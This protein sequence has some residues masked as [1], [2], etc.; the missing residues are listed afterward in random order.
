MRGK[1]SE[2]NTWIGV[3]FRDDRRHLNV[4]RLLLSASRH[5]RLLGNL[6]AST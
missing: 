3:I 1:E 6:P 4:N 2:E 5:L